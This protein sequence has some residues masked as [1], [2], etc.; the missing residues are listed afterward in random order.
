MPTPHRLLKKMAGPFIKRAT[1][2]Y[3]S[4][5]EVL[6]GFIDG[7]GFLLT[8]PK[9]GTNFIVNV[10][11]FYNAE[12]IGD[13][14]L[15]LDDRYSLGIV[16]GGHIVRD[17]RGITEALK[18]HRRSQQM[19]ITRFHDEVPGV[20]PALLIA[21]TRNVLDQFT[22]LWYYQYETRGISVDAAIP[23]LVQ[24]YVVRNRA[25]ARIAERSDKAL[26]V[27]YEDLIERP[28]QAFEAILTA[29][30]GTCQIEPLRRAIER[31]S[32][33]NFKEW[34]AKRG[35]PAISEELAKTQKSFIRSGKIGEG[36]EFF[37]EAQKE[38]IARLMRESGISLDGDHAAL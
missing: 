32:P 16:H 28:E 36:E 7:Q 31:S 13:N 35:K 29:A 18:F 5:V 19:M 8:Q 11:A 9:T 22:S 21:T 30:Y 23:E 1:K 14:E 24:K 10:I 26:F 25:Q 4:N 34:E 20:Q 33:K 38:Q 2:N 12:L 17:S 37:S 6:K 27:R 15:T 3:L